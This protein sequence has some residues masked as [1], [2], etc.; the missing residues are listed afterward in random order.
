MKEEAVL[1]EIRGPPTFT[2]VERCTEK[3]LHRYLGLS[4]PIPSQARPTAR[5]SSIYCG[6]QWCKLGISSPT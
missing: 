3:H 2:S 4:V 5:L 1:G 6:L